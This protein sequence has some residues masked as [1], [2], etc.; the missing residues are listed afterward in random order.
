LHP[1]V[2][3]VNPDFTGL[4]A[5]QCGI[6]IFLNRNTQQFHSCTSNP[7]G[8]PEGFYA[9]SQ[10]AISEGACASCF[11][12]PD[13]FISAYR[14]FLNCDIMRCILSPLLSMCIILRICSY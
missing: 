12:R 5:Q 13:L 2:I 11:L 4:N 1:V 10:H 6:G 7:L 9:G 14:A 3:V 8:Q